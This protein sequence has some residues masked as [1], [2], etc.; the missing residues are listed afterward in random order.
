VDLQLRRSLKSASENRM[1]R[2]GDT[3]EHWK[4]K[5]SPGKGLAE[6]N[7]HAGSDRE[8]KK[9]FF[10]S[11]GATSRRGTRAKPTVD[12]EGRGSESLS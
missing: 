6:S 9:N 3:R 2:G 4:K 12:Q 11:G 8:K 7:P 1:R 5:G 10:L